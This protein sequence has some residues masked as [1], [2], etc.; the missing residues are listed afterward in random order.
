MDSL[1][2]KPLLPITTKSPTIQMPATFAQQSKINT[3]F[4]H[5]KPKKAKTNLQNCYQHILTA[6]GYYL[7]IFS[8]ILPA[9]KVKRSLFYSSIS[10]Y[11]YTSSSPR[12]VASSAQLVTTLAILL[13]QWYSPIKSIK[14]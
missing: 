7:V 13:A 12:L 3:L 14:S 11:I 6:K 1:S 10:I 8:R 2:L 9:E 4:S 5:N